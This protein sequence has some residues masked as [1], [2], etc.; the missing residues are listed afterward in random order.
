MRTSSRVRMAAGLALWLVAASE[1]WA[2]GPPNG[3]RAVGERVYREVCAAC[4]G[5]TGDGRG[6]S[7]SGLMP[8]PQVFANGRH[9]MRLTD[10]YLF[11]VVKYG[12]M[13][14][15]KGQSPRPG[16]EATA[17]PAFEEVFSDAQIRELVA[18][19][20]AFRS[21]VPQPAVLRATFVEYCVICHGAEGRGDGKLA[22]KRQPPPPRFVSAL[23]PAPPDYRDAAMMDRFSD[24]FLFTLIKKGRIRATEAAG[25]DTMKPLGQ[26]LSDAEIWAVVRYIRDI[27]VRVEREDGAVRDATATPRSTDR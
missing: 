19:V 9:M 23:Q 16:V 3:A 13:A 10:E 4:H 27:L 21:G 14:V 26:V 20:R 18:Y 2:A 6:P 22:S 8:R 25:F 17:M 11:A 15:L 7:A 1:A 24:D 5:A 12:K